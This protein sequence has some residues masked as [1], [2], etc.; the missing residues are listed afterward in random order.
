MLRG[1]NRYDIFIIVVIATMV[2]GT[3]NIW[4]FF[5]HVI[6]AILSIPVI[7]KKMTEWQRGRKM[8]YVTSYIFILLLWACVS[9]MWTI[10]SDGG[11]G[12]LFV[13][14]CNLMIFLGLYFASDYAARPC[15]SICYGWLL[16]LCLSFPVAFW[17][18]S[19]GS[20]IPYFGDYN[21][22][23]M[24]VGADGVSQDRRFAAV[25]FKNLNTYGTVLCS[26][27]PF[28]LAACFLM[29]EKFIP[30]CIS[31]AAIVILIINSS[32][33][34]M[35]CIAIDLFF[36]LVYFRKERFR[37]MIFF[38]FVMSVL[39]VVGLYEFSSVLFNQ[40]A[41]R[42]DSVSFG[43]ALRWA[44]IEYG[45][46][47]IAASYGVGWGV[48]SM[49]EAYLIVGYTI[50]LFSHN[51]VIEFML[52]YGVLMCLSFLLLYVR[53]LYLLYR[54][55]LNVLRFLSLA[56]LFSLVPWAIIN[57]SYLEFNFIWA[58]FAS[59]FVFY[60]YRGQFGVC[61]YEI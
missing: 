7:A 44:V 45:L 1:L 26:A 59:L 41:G 6:A 22:G 17:E 36:F 46:K 39:V 29:R 13:L 2:M 34:S 23:S 28:V 37:G 33:A 55:K 58:M 49:Q 56:L 9:L 5:Q 60:R 20:H 48:G 30:L 52:E 24:L 43:D 32:R 27:L 8:D 54:T 15:T 16:L 47:S 40:I 38:W 25:T 11:Y 19:T 31:L 50:L 4:I 21:D 51:F 61:K 10:D 3:L 57:D 53:S 12:S 35:M 42:L 18:I 14:T